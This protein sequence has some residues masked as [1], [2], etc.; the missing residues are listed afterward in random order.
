MSRDL[1]SLRIYAHASQTVTVDIHGPFVPAGFIYVL[2]DI[3]MV[4]IS[5]TRPAEAFVF[6]AVG[7]PLW[8]VLAQ[9]SD[10]EGNHQWRGRQVYAVGEQVGFQVF[11]VMWY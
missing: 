9:S 2:R 10:I 3:D 6:N 7:G 4:E 1:Y 8:N 11:S 5:G